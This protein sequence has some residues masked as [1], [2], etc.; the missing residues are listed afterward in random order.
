MIRKMNV[1]GGMP[2]TDTH[3]PPKYRRIGLLNLSAI[4]Y[5]LGKINSVIKKAN[6]NP[7]MIVQDKGFQNTALSPPKNICGLSSANRVTK[8]I[9]N[10]TARGIN[11]RIAAKAV[12]KTGIILVF[13]ARISASLVFIPRSRK[14]V[15]KFDHENSILDYNPREPYDS[16]SGHDH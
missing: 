14:Y 5:I 2:I 16:K 3:L 15:C 4:M 6:A 12:S 11:A 9:L 10:P 8:L 7:N 1:R 13:P